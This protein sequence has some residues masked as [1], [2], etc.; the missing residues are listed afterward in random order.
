MTNQPIINKIKSQHCIGY[1]FTEFTT[2]SIFI[3]VGFDMDGVCWQWET[4][5]TRA[6]APFATISE[7]DIA[8]SY[9]R[10]VKESTS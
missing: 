1:R 8:G 7:K 4:E 2:V 3:N 9:R 5:E 6:N 10:L